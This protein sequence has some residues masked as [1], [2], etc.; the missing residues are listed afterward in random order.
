MLRRMFGK[1]GAGNTPPLAGAGEGGE[2]AQPDESMLSQQPAGAPPA[3]ERSSEH[4]APPS[5]WSPAGDETAPT[6]APATPPVWPEPPT[7]TPA[8]D[9]PAS[10]R[11]PEEATEATAA[12]AEDA[13]PSNSS[14]LAA[15]TW[16]PFTPPPAAPPNDA[17]PK[18]AAGPWSAAAARE[19]HAPADEASSAPGAATGTSTDAASTASNEAASASA[20][21][22]SSEAAILSTAGSQPPEGALPSCETPAATGSAHD[23]SE[24]ES[25]SEPD[26]T[27]SASTPPVA[28]APAAGADPA[29]KPAGASAFMT[30]ASA[31]VSAAA[32][33][34]VPDT[35]EPSE[36]QPAG[37]PSP[38]GAGSPPKDAASVRAAAPDA[39]ATSAAPDTGSPPAAA[40]SQ[41]PETAALSTAAVSSKPEAVAPATAAREVETAAPHAQPAVEPQTEPRPGAAASDQPATGAAVGPAQPQRPFAGAAR[42]T[43]AAAFVVDPMDRARKALEEAKRQMPGMLETGPEAHRSALGAGSAPRQTPAPRPA[44]SIEWPG[45]LEQL[46][47]TRQGLAG[48]VA[49]LRGVVAELQ[50][51]VNRLVGAVG[52]LNRGSPPAVAARPPI[53]PSEGAALGEALPR[54]YGMLE[55]LRSLSP[56]AESGLTPPSSGAPPVG[57]AVPAPP[58]PPVRVEVP[59]PQGAESLPPGVVWPG[60]VPHVHV[61]SP[62]HGVAAGTLAA[63]A[64]LAGASALMGGPQ[65]EAHGQAAGG[66]GSIT[67]TVFP[68]E[69]IARLSAL[70]RRLAGSTPVQ[71]LELSGYRR[72]EATFRAVLVAGATVQDVVRHVPDEGVRVVEVLLDDGGASARV[73]IAATAPN[74]APASA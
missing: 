49:D 28:T 51:E 10:L 69:G 58:L 47:E 3:G 63:A 20:E 12:V 34:S 56:S 25:A 29:P 4:F 62:A 46:R 40:A 19:R 21:A 33:A 61:P 57:S 41:A 70:E 44:G 37:H 30:A 13:R 23:A 45:V 59:R 2:A 16:T 32:T 35:V 71:R 55:R 22:P 54:L 72:G 31:S 27:A 17:E 50:A 8:H 15:E 67:L 6:S 36:Q 9:E 53:P 74:A 73:R 42:E 60:T 7:P 24:L 26:G 52:S 43:A 64:G 68:V 18:T 5:A 39:T 1:G 38:E 14:R 11:Q 65:G 48:Q 66:Q